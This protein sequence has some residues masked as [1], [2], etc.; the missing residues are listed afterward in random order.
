MNIIDHKPQQATDRILPNEI[1]GKKEKKIALFFI[2]VYKYIIDN[3]YK[4][5]T[6][7]SRTK[8]SDS[9][10]KEWRIWDLAI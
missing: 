2:M 6:V 4:H 10:R 7:N 5:R 1:Y 3:R 9:Q 8:I